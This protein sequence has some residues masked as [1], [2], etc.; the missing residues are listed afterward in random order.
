MTSASQA[1]FKFSRFHSRLR[2]TWET[3]ARVSSLPRR[4]PRSA[5]AY[6]RIKA[7]SRLASLFIYMT[8]FMLRYNINV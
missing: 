8:I 7:A 4:W 2:L 6:S 3:R 1:S 5:S